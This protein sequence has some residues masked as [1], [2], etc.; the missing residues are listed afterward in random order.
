MC[1]TGGRIYAQHEQR[2]IFTFLRWCPWVYLQ[3]PVQFLWGERALRQERGLGVARR[4]LAA[5]A[6][7]IAAHGKSTVVGVPRCRC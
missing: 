7:A 4:P 3:Y 6:A 5:A 1:T 2:A